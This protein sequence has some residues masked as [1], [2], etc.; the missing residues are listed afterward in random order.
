[1]ENKSSFNPLWLT[2]ACE[3]LRVF[4]DFREI[5]IYITQLKD[6]LTEYENNF[7]LFL[8]LRLFIME[9]KLKMIQNNSRNFV[10]F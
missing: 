9:F 4:G 6:G 2:V 3:E 7:E 8:L 10:A 1:M 5:N